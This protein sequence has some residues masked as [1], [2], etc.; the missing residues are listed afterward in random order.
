VT[1]VHQR[2]DVIDSAGK[3]VSTDPRQRVTLIALT[4][5]QGDR[6]LL[7]DTAPE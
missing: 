3:V 4:M 1:A 6:W 5:W 7:Y 2:V